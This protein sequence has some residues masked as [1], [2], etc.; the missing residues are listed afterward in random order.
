MKGKFVVFEGIDAAG[1]STQVYRLNNFI[2]MQGLPCVMT[3][4]PTDNL[5]GGVIRAAL[6]KEWKTDIR[7][8]QL[9]FSADRSHHLKTI[10]EPAL[11]AGK[12]VISDR[13]FL[14]TIAYGS[15]ELDKKWLRQV[16]KEFPVPD[17]AFVID[18]PPEVSLDRVDKSRALNELFEEKEK[19]QKIRK[20]Y[21]ELA[22]ELKGEGWNIH[23]LNGTKPIE[24]VHEEVKRIINQGV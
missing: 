7:T 16:S 22:E 21:L 11:E 6:R 13:Y 15:L 5:I 18:V 9:L 1:M 17:F 23:L 20:N 14:S 24:E 12:W 3:K 2:K 10:V 8:L 4:E 19:L